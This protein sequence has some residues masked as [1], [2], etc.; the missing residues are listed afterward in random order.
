MQALES[1]LACDGSER[2]TD[3]D[4][5]R[6]GLEPKT[7]RRAFFARY[8]MTFHAWQRAQGLARA[9]ERLEG[10]E[11]VLAAGL[12]GGYAS[13]SGFRSAFSQLFGA[14]P[15]RGRAASVC[16][17]R[18]LP[19]PL[20]ALIAVASER[21]I[22]LVEFADHAHLERQ[23]RD[24]ARRRASALVP[25]S[26]RHLEQLAL[27]LREYF[28]GRRLVFEVEL[29]VAG[30]PFQLAVWE[31]LRAIPAGQT[32]S[33]AELAAALGRPGAQRA[34]ARA[35]ASNH[36]AILIPCHRVIGSDGRLV[37]YGGGLW[38]KRRLL[39]LEAAAV[40]KAIQRRPLPELSLASASS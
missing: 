11:S 28:A 2:L 27:E 1:E 33:Y 8:R 18:L 39:E 32:R 5:A 12:D 38:R 30:A 17:A 26:N 13:T 29:D 10:G 37:G 21:G 3:A 14:P 15:S 35:N 23:T 19:S 9:R 36:L 40:R 24:L 20:G 31:A 34:V 7:V 6:R 22:C 25:G 4:L 16:R